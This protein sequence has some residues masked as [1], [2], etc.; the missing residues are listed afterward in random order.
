[1]RFA[2][3]IS[4]KIAVGFAGILCST[5]PALTGADIEGTV[6]VK[7]R[8]TKPRV[9]APSNPYE[10]G[11]AVELPSN[12]EIDVLAFERSRV[13]VF[14]DGALPSEP[15]TATLEQKNRQFAPD[16]LVVPVGSTV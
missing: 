6:I 15:R 16:T 3:L 4:P 10:R 13:I 14:L 1:M 11:V 9:T 2:G 5:V 12:P 7:H 8:L